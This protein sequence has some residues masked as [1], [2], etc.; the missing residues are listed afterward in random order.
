[1]APL[2]VLEL[3][4]VPLFVSLRMLTKS[5]WVQTLTSVVFRAS[6]SYPRGNTVLARL[7]LLVV[8]I[9]A[10]LRHFLFPLKQLALKSEH[11]FPRLVRISPLEPFCF[12]KTSQDIKNVL[13]SD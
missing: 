2:H 5:L 11:L 1:M 13:T 9:Q 3:E 7:V 10:V 8:F 4:L 12:R 6:V